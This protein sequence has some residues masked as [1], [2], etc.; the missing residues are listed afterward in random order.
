M[1]GFLFVLAIDYGMKQTI[2]DHESGI[3][4]KFTTKLEDLDFADHLALL[5]SKF[6]RIQL[7]TDKLQE[8]ANKMG[9]KIN[10]YNT[11]VMCMNTTNNNPVKLNEKEPGDIDTIT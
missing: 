7:K 9:L 6:Q 2:K 10:T 5:F 3:R 1:S 11:K 8:N 4:W